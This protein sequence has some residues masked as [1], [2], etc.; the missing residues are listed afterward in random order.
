MIRFFFFHKTQNNLSLRDYKRQNFVKR[1]KNKTKLTTG[2][3]MSEIF[4]GIN[5]HINFF[6]SND[7]NAS[8]LINLFL[9][10]HVSPVQSP[11]GSVAKKQASSSV[12]NNCRSRQRRQVYDNHRSN[13]DKTSAKYLFR[14]PTAKY[15]FLIK[16]H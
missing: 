14:W 11:N 3:N 4:L 2:K 15:P 16:R 10:Q 9:L 12:H 13:W 6:S 5:E 8:K 1:L 7:F